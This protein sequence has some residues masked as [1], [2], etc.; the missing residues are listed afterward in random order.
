MIRKTF[1]IRGMTCPNCAMNIE[2]LEDDLP[3][4]RSVTASYLKG[5]MEV[6]FDER[7]VSEEEILAAVA[8]LGYQAQAM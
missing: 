8:R 2:R 4:I 3:G 1:R 6:E 7:R 5:S